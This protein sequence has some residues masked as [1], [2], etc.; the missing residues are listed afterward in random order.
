MCESKLHLL[1]PG[2]L[3]HVVPGL[4]LKLILDGA[5]R[6]GQL[7]RKGDLPRLRRDA[8]SFHKATADNVLHGKEG[9]IT[10]LAATLS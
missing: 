9:Y 2:E 4:A 6:G 7:E 5:G 1:N 8:E 10:S 3:C